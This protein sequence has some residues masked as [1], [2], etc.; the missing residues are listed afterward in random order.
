M[1]VFDSHSNGQLNE[2]NVDDIHDS[3]LPG[4]V[5]V[6]SPIAIKPRLLDS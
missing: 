4:D 2:E 6:C 5:M 1:L 3:A